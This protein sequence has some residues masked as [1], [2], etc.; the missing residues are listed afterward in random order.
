MSLIQFVE[1]ITVAK[2][3]EF[4]DAK[5]LKIYLDSIIAGIDDAN[6]EEIWYDNI[7]RSISNWIN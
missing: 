6:D 4:K 3:K 2:N 5:Q 7:G 1:F